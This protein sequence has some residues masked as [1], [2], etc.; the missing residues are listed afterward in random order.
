M[1]DVLDPVIKT[2]KAAIDLFGHGPIVLTVCILVELVGVPK[3]SGSQRS[4][5]GRGHQLGLHDQVHAK[6]FAGME[7][8]AG[9]SQLDA[10]SSNKTPGITRSLISVAHPVAVNSRGNELW[11]SG[12]GLG[13]GRVKALGP[14]LLQGFSPVI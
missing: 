11:V 5:L 6:R 12:A 13:L 7:I 1:V 8:I 9:A 14:E 10:A 4:I 3:P 2:N